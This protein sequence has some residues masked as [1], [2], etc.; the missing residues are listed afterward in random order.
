MAANGA[1]G[2]GPPPAGGGGLPVP[3]LRTIEELCQPSL[4]GRG[5][6]IAPIS[7][8]ATTFGLKNDQAVPI[9]KELRALRDRVDVAEAES[10]SLRATI[11]TIGAV[12]TVL[13]NRI[14]DERHARIKIERQLASVQESHR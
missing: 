4:D 8:Q 5:G 3:D 14:R 1:G 12:E 10:A 13:R 7:I 6:P 11:R 9:Q 2:A